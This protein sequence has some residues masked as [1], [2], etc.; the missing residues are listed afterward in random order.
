VL[1]R[2]LFYNIFFIFL[3]LFLLFFFSAFAFQIKS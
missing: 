2:R 1:G 3:R